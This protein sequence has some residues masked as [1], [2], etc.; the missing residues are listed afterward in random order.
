MDRSTATT[1]DNWTS[2]WQ[3]MF[4]SISPA[5]AIRS[6]CD[7]TEFIYLR[8]EE[9]QT[10]WD[11]RAH[12][13]RGQSY[14]ASEVLSIFPLASNLWELLVHRSYVSRLKG[15]A[16]SVDYIVEEGCHP[17]KPPTCHLELRDRATWHLLAIERLVARAVAIN[18]LSKAQQSTKADAASV[19]LRV[20]MLYQCSPVFQEVQLTV[21]ELGSLGPLTSSS[22]I[23]ADQVYYL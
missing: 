19:Y 20:V 7:G 1:T 16:P 15:R 21:S 5:L 17:I 8:A 6:V 14:K 9:D 4:R 22:C 10:A 11:V 3:W 13:E 2:L 18:L 12:L 23:I